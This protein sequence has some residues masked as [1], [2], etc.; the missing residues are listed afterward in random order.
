M[1]NPNSE[2]GTGPAPRNSAS[3]ANPPSVPVIPAT[4][5]S[6]SYATNNQFQFT[7]TGTAWTNYIVQ[8]STTLATT[9]WLALFT[10][11]APFTFPNQRRRIP[12]AVLSR[13]V[14]AVKLGTPRCEI[15]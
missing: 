8:G 14:P 12:A 10:N 1:I 5:G 4:L 11:A 15:D 2:I 3:P 7:V 9:N 6:L 13:G